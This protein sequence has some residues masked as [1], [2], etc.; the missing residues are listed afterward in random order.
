MRA[1]SASFVRLCRAGAA[2]S[3]ALAATPSLAA[4]VTPPQTL[5]SQQI[6]SVSGTVTGIH[7][8]PGDMARIYITTDVGSVWIMKGSTRLT[9]PMLA[10]PN[11]DSS[12]ENGLLGMAFDPQFQT[13]RKFYVFVRSALVAGGTSLPRVLSYTMMPG[14]WDQ[15]DPASRQVVIEMTA[16]GIHVGG[17]IGFGT[18]GYLYIS[19]GDNGP[20]GNAQSLDMLNGK[21]LRIDPSGDDFPA[22]ANKNYAIP[23][24]NPFAGA[25]PG[26]DEIFHLGLRNP[27]RCSFDRLTGDFYIADVGANTRE[28]VNRIPLGHAGGKNFGWPCR[29]GFLGTSN[30]TTGCSGPTANNVDPIVDLVRSQ[31]NCLIGGVVYRG[32]EIPELY[33]KYI[34]GECGSSKY[35]TFDPT[36]PFETLVPQLG[37]ASGV[38]S[39]GEDAWGELYYG[40]LSGGVYKVNRWERAPQLTDCNLNGTMDLCE[41]ARG[42]TRD[43]NHNNIP[44]TCEGACAGDLNSDGSVTADDLFAFLDHWMRD[45]G[46][47]GIGLIADADW[48]GAV[49]A[50]DIWAFLAIWFEDQRGC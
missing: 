32:C 38:T 25:I 50:D 35:Y 27:F 16:S 22:D 19:R 3:I 13:N 44:D 5:I 42:F 31:S 37:L 33:G 21:I 1:H 26:A 9:T 14:S 2:F 40:T 20:S 28:E 39:W 29:E 48:N 49:T 47:S 15:A 36:D 30:T 18:D 7:H 8:A 12:G 41:I 17:W 46:H 4:P 43:D 11:V 24:S 45:N 6:T 34:L 23:A 10:I